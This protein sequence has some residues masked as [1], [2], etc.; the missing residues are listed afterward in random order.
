M[1]IRN[2][3]GFTVKADGYH[4]FGWLVARGTDK[5]WSIYRPDGSLHSTN[6]NHDSALHD[7]KM[8]A[9]GLA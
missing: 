5:S 6:T 9:F 8:A 3:K 7:C 1:M 4:Y 2:Y